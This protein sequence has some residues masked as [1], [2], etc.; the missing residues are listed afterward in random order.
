MNLK[1]V[2]EI[3]YPVGGKSKK[4]VW[5]KN[6]GYRT[7]QEFFD[8]LI[9]AEMRWLNMKLWNDK[10]RRRRFLSDS[11]K[12]SRYLSSLRTFILQNAFIIPRMEGKG[13]KML[14]GNICEAEMNRIF[15]EI[16]ETE[17]I[18]FSLDL[19]KH[20]IDE[21]NG[22]LK[23]EWGNV[24]TFLTLY[25]IFPTEVNQLYG[26][27][28][29]K[30]DNDDRISENKSSRP[31]KSQFQ[32]EYP[33]DMGIFEPG[34]IIVHTWIIKNAGEAIWE[35]RYLECDDDAPFLQ[36]D[37]AS[38]IEIPEVVYPGDTISP[39][40]WFHAP[41]KPGAYA[42]TWRIKDSSGKII[43]LDKLG[44][45]LHFIVLEECSTKKN[46]DNNYRVLK[47]VP[48]IPVT[49]EVGTLYT[50]TWLIEN[51]GSV[52]W[53]DYGCE[54]INGECFHYTKKE[55][56]IPLKKQVRPGDQV[57]VKAEFVLPPV[58]GVYRLVWRIVDR[59]GK[60]VFPN[61]RRLEVLL[62]VI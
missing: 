40:V 59:D 42:L 51:T 48:D 12:E 22:K 35:N 7:K 9:P 56:Q 47:E 19:K 61:D 17:Q 62:N 49:L 43:S 44:V 11:K 46:E 57:S 52:T 26:P 54:C 39:T 8:T 1:G 31:D 33:P 45:G 27:Y 24:L 37:H 14:N 32:S 60:A 6:P 13:E 5:N 2:Y 18:I 41:D 21:K 55:L 15:F 38:K 53:Q 20:L 10:A 50:H 4:S 29:F 30:K 16:V 34:E 36:A 58:E 28:L 3:F 25:A 23:P